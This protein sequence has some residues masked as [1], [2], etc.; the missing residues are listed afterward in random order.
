MDT[1]LNWVFAQINKD[2]LENDLIN[3]FNEIKNP[4]IIQKVLPWSSP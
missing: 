3:K 2:Q 1:V 4:T